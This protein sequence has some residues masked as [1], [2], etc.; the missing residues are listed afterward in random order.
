MRCGGV[1]HAGGI[2]DLCSTAGFGITRLAKAVKSP[3]TDSMQS[4][5]AQRF[6]HSCAD[7]SE[8]VDDVAVDGTAVDGVR[9]H[10]AAIGT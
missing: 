7:I 9:G 5:F 6:P 8:L 10:L 3:L 1:W 4:P 2:L